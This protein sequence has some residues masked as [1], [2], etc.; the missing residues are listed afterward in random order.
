MTK[1]IPWTGRAVNFFLLDENPRMESDG[2]GSFTPAGTAFFEEKKE[3]FAAG[4][5]CTTHHFDAAA[6]WIDGEISS[7]LASAWFPGIT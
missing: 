5:N 6:N 7:I 4:L 2:K 3:N 1:L